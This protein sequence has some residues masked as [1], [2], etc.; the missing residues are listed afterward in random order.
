M[1]KMVSTHAANE[2]GVTAVAWLW[3]SYEHQR[4][5]TYELISVSYMKLTEIYLSFIYY[6]KLSS[7][8]WLFHTL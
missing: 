1:I 4:E 2:Q 7:L 8:C 6:A 3:I 5:N